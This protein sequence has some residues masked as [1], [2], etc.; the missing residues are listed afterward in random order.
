LDLLTKVA[1]WTAQNEALLSGTAAMIV[2]AGMIFTPLGTALRRIATGANE[3]TAEERQ[4]AQPEPALEAKTE[5]TGMS[6]GPDRA[7]ES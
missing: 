3:R 2:V 6:R 7:P 5:A 1:P 4:T